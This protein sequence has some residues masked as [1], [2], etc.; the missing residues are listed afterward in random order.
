MMLKDTPLRK[1]L[2][3]P[4]AGMIDNTLTKEKI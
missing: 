1:S 3:M 2:F 4:L